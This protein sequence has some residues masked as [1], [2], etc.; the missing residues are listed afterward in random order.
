MNFDI[1]NFLP[2]WKRPLTL[3]VGCVLF[4][5]HEASTAGYIMDVPDYLYPILAMFGF[6]ALSH[7]SK[8]DAAKP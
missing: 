6:N 7:A 2:G 3:I 8:N 4:V 1:L 5:W